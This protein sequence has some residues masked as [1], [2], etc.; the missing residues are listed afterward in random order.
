[1]SHTIKLIF[2]L[3]NEKNEPQLAIVRKKEVT[4]GNAVKA[5][6]FVQDEV[7]Y[8]FDA[9]TDLLGSAEEEE[10]LTALLNRQ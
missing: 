4:L 3:I 7:D 2:A 10:C 9:A 8:F 5:F 1:M 6:E